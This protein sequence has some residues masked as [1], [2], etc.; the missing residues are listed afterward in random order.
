MEPNYIFYKELE[1]EDKGNFRI[2]LTKNNKLENV[3][4]RKDKKYLLTNM[5]IKPKIEEDITK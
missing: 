3:R 5:K 2:N 4:S 1:V